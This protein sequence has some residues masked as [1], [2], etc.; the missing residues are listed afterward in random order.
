MTRIYLRISFAILAIALSSSP[1]YAMGKKAGDDKPASATTEQE[2][3][4][5]PFSHGKEMHQDHCNKCHTDDIYKRDDRI[6]KSINAL[7]KQVRI[8]KDNTG[9][10]W[11]DEDTDAVVHFL[12]KQYYKF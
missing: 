6:V 10:P 11:F 4:A 9:T 12:N 3:A 2:I 7:G 8:C 5:D 1:V